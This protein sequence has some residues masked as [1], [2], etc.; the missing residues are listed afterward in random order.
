MATETST[1]ELL[2]RL[3]ELEDKQA[4]ASLMNRYV[5]AVDAFDWEAWGGCWA[6]DAIA[7]FGRSGRLDGRERIVATARE[8]QD[9]YRARGGMQHLVANLEFAVTGNTAENRRLPDPSAA[10]Q[11]PRPHYAICGK[12][13]WEFARGADGWQITRAQLRRIWTAE[14]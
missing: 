9:A 2:A 6:A 8:R 3:R 5:E 4:L 11:S 14:P 7:D 13:R 1:E 10:L 12:Y